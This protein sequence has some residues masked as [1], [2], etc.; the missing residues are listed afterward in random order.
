MAAVLL[1]GTRD[2]VHVIEDGRTLDV[3][4]PVSAL[5]SDGGVWAV[6]GDHR[7]QLSPD[8]LQW[9]PTATIPDLAIRCVLPAKGATYLGTSEAH[10][11]RL[12]DGEPQQVDAFEEV[13]GRDTWH[14]PWGGPPDTRSLSIADDGA[15]YANVHVGGIPRSADEGRTWTPTID[16]DADVHQV[17]AHR[18]LVLAACAP[19]LA[20]SSDAGRTWRIDADGLHARY[21]RAV[22]VCDDTLLVSASTGPFTEQAAVY[23]RPVRSDGAFEKCAG[24][25]PEWFGANVDTRCL[26][27]DDERAAIG[28]DEGEVWL[29]EDQGR[30][31]ERA[32]S[33]LLTLSCLTFVGASA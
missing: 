23:R 3:G 8:G 12:Q 16:I 7:V 11:Y 31:W 27:T 20:V 22:A 19:G 18:D 17:L 4:G 2:G 10:L 5:A 21:C 1:G 9:T 28:T 14:T 32:A 25:L 29:S 26:V 13:E 33:G 15:L 30:S 24:G 6:T